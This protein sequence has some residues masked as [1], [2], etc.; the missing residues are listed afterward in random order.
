M[1]RLGKRDL[2]KST[3]T[4]IPDDEKLNGIC[5]KPWTEMASHCSVRLKC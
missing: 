1:L 3:E 2:R 4:I 5:P